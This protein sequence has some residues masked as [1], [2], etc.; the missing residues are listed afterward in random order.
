MKNIIIPLLVVA[1]GLPCNGQSS[2]AETL[3]M[4][5]QTNMSQQ[6]SNPTATMTSSSRLFGAKEDLTSVIF[7]IPSGSTVTILSSDSTYY[8]VAFEDSEGY[9]FKRH[10]VIDNT[11]VTPPQNIQQPEP[12]QEVQQEQP[13]QMSRFSY[14]EN[15]YG[16]NMAARLIAGKI[17]RGMNA[18]MVK[19]SW[20][21][22]EK[23]NRVISGNIIKEEWIFKNTWLYFENN[24]LVEWGPLKQ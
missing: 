8:H 9:I 15:K 4:L 22:A 3:Q 11:P 17:W 12:V 21:T 7:I 14:L 2:K 5:E 13:Q 18:E 10:A 20:G 24:S 1:M 16:S 19:D 23:I 6:E